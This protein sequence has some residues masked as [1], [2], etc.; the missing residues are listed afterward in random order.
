MIAMSVRDD[1]PVEPAR[2][3]PRAAAAARSGPQ[4]TSIRSPPLSTRIE[5]RR[6]ALRGSCGIALAPVV[7]DL[8]DAGRRPAAE[9][10]DLH[11]AALL[12]NLKK[13]AVVASA[14][15]SGSSPLS[16]AT[17]L[18][19]SATNAGSH[20]WPRCGTGA[21]NG[22]IGLDQ[23]L[24][25]GQPFG[26]LLQVRGVLERHDARQRDVEAEVEALARKLGRAGEAVEDAGD[27][28]LPAPP[29]RGFRP[30]PPPHRGCGRRAAGRSA[31]PRRYAP[32]N[33]SRCAARSDLS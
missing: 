16:S 13:L 19:V 11:A 23:H 9:N 20:F 29:R 14:S 7:A 8:R 30:C 2:P 18:A 1:H 6:R 32:A 25:R 17:K 15:S 27:A 22:R 12:N 31:A 3:R 28:A 10:P 21:R 5:V 4:S 24:V 26:G 33:R